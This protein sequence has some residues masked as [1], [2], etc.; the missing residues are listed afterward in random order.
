MV[1]FVFFVF[2]FWGMWFWMLDGWKAIPRHDKKLVELYKRAKLGFLRQPI[3]KLFA[4][5]IQ[6]PMFSVDLKFV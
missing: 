3:G 5:I 4:H 1:V 2:C 6:H